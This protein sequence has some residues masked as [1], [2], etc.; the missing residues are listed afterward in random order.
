MI[1]LPVHAD[2]PGLER[3]HG[4]I[5]RR[6][7]RSVEGRPAR[8]GT[9]AVAADA[10]R[11]TLPLDALDHAQAPEREAS[12]SEL[13]RTVY[14]TIREHA[15]ANGSG[16]L[17]AARVALRITRLYVLDSAG[18]TDAEAAR[19]LGVTDRTLRLD[20]E[21]LRGVPRAEFVSGGELRRVPPPAERITVHHAQGGAAA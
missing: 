6:R 16:S 21:R 13:G 7:H 2:D 5:E 14:W 17:A 19:A 11:E 10:T 9:L 20:R 15:E 12:L 8:V 3:L 4:A 18:F 1:P